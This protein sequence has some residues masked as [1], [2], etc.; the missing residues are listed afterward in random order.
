VILQVEA[1]R[2]F[3]AFILMTGPELDFA[4]L[5]FSERDQISPNCRGPGYL[6]QFALPS[7]AAHPLLISSL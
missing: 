3:R 1:L 2:G 7:L 4:L 5:D 6:L